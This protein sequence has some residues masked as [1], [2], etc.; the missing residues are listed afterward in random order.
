[1][2][3]YIYEKNLLLFHA[4]ASLKAVESSHEN[5]T[6][7]HRLVNAY[8]DFKDRF[9]DDDE[10]VRSDMFAAFRSLFRTPK[11]EIKE[12]NEHIAS[13]A[14]FMSAMSQ[15]HDA[16]HESDLPRRARMLDDVKDMLDESVRHSVGTPDGNGTSAFMQGVDALKIGIDMQ[17]ESINENIVV[18]LVDPKEGLAVDRIAQISRDVTEGNLSEG[19]EHWLRKRMKSMRQSAMKHISIGVGIGLAAGLGFVV[20]SVGY[21]SVAVTNGVQGACGFIALYAGYQLKRGV[22]DANKFMAARYVL[23]RAMPKTGQTGSTQ[24]EIEPERELR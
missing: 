12:L 5:V 17:R 4:V 11:D 8:H 16:C 1:M 24:V 19:T 23:R 3:I 14:L 21:L 15:F 9:Y 6:R 10:R 2:G 22:S 7:R 13:N 20:S 18:T